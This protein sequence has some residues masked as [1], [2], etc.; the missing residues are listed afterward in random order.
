M[1][2]TIILGTR[3]YDMPRTNVQAIDYSQSIDRTV[4]EGESDRFVVSNEELAAEEAVRQPTRSG[5][6]GHVEVILYRRDGR[7]YS[8]T[9]WTTKSY[10]IDKIV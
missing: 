2:D 7:I 8:A 5:N 9:V 3:R 4:Q 1:S 10:L 6:L